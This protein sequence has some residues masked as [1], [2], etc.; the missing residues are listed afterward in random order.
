M[1]FL[2]EILST[3]PWMQSSWANWRSF[4]LT[5]VWLQQESRKT[6]PA[7]DDWQ[8]PPKPPHM[9]GW[10]QSMPQ[11]ALTLHTHH[12]SIL[13]ACAVP[14]SPCAGQGF[15]QLKGLG[16]TET[17]APRYYLHIKTYLPKEPRACNPRQDRYTLN[18]CVTSTQP[19]A[20]KGKHIL[21]KM[22]VG[23]RQKLHS[24]VLSSR[25]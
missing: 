23:W 14:V 12:K 10:F 22:W 21:L 19:F 5:I 18:I 2:S 17:V 25:E 3:G 20:D 1:H 9:M 13:N 6:T 8:V 11:Y 7:V 15:K 24:V 4:V 16:M